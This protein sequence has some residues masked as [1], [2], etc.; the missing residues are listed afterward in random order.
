MIIIYF[1]AANSLTSVR[2]Y[3]DTVFTGRLYAQCAQRRY[4]RLGKREQTHIHSH[5]KK[6]CR[7]SSGGLGAIAIVRKSRD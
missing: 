3:R 5:Y 6:R 4:R 2:L 7:K 1:A